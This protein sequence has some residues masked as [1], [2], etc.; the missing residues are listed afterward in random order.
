M[1]N[2]AFLIGMLAAMF[3]GGLIQAKLAKTDDG[4]SFSLGYAFAALVALLAVIA[5]TIWGPR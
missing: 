3:G 5:H 1:L 2:H 4:S